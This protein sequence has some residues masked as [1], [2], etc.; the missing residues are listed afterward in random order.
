MQ[1][2]F[3][4]P[5]APFGYKKKQRSNPIVPDTRILIIDSRAARAVRK[6]FEMY[7]TGKFTY[8]D[9]ADMLNRRGFLTAY[10]KPFCRQNIYF[11]LKNEVYIGKIV[12]KKEIYPGRHEAIISQE[13]WDQVQA[14]RRSKGNM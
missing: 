4:N 6:C 10:G 14:V 8:D 7:S 2:Y 3:T 1:G 5:F 12:Y 13:L 9:L 11:M